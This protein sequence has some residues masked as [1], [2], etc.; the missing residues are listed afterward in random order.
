MA[1]LSF[2]ACVTAAALVPALSD[3]LTPA[4]PSLFRTRSA[5]AVHALKKNAAEGVHGMTLAPVTLADIP[6]Y[7]ELE[8][9]E[10]DQSMHT[11]VHLL[12]GGAVQLGRTDGPLPTTFE[13]SWAITDEST[14]AFELRVKRTFSEA[15]R[16]PYDVERVYKGYVDDDKGL[17]T[18]SGPIRIQDPSMRARRGARR[19]AAVALERTAQG[20]RSGSPAAPLQAA[21]VSARSRGAR[22]PSYSHAARPLPIAPLA[23]PQTV[24]RSSRASSCSPTCPSSRRRRT[25]RQRELSLTSVCLLAAQSSANR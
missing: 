4:K 7:W 8:E 22:T 25:P 23:A 21:G 15:E 16:F 13:A 1:P 9:D 18:V 19:A 20:V 12:P 11:L 17:R 5:F 6:G 14:W 10:D 3:A 24:A 2:L